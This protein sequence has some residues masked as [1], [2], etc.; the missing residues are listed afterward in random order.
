MSIISQYKRIFG[1]SKFNYL[2][3][4]FFDIWGIPHE[5]L[6]KLPKQKYIYPV[7]A[8]PAWVSLSIQNNHQLIASIPFF[9]TV[10]MGS[11][12]SVFK[13]IKLSLIIKAPAVIGSRSKKCDL[14]PCY[15]QVYCTTTYLTFQ[16]FKKMFKFNSDLMATRIWWFFH[17]MVPFNRA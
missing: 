7:F 14:F 4:W 9:F 12:F 10:G 13:N 16:Y 1:G 11:V 8:H 15:T 6:G 2:Y 5:V 3:I 17:L